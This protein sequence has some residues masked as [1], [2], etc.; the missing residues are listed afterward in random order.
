MLTTPI[1][2]GRVRR[3]RLTLTRARGVVSTVSTVSTVVSI[4]LPI[5]RRDDTLDIPP[6][7]EAL[8]GKSEDE[9]KIDGWA[10][11]ALNRTAGQATN[12]LALGEDVEDDRRDYGGH[13]VRQD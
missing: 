12:E 3:M 9:P 8:V 5:E 7:H 1:R 6:Q 4:S 10:T 13:R 11:S 2:L